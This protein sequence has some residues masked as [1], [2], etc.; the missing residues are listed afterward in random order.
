[1][2]TGVAKNID[3]IA[4]DVHFLA[5]P[6]RLIWHL[7]IIFVL[8]FVSPLIFGAVVLGLI[9]NENFGFAIRNWLLSLGWFPPIWASQFGNPLTKEDVWVLRIA[10]GV[11]GP[12]AFTF[13]FAIVT[14]WREVRR[15]KSRDGV[16]WANIRGLLGMVMSFAGMIASLLF[17]YRYN[18]EGQASL[19]VMALGIMSP[20]LVWYM[21]G[22][23][24]ELA[25]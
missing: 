17:C 19:L 25:G 11:F 21:L 5:A 16:L 2:D 1:M 13:W 4:G 23:L 10:L 14:R 6:F 12:F 9:I 18:V 8:L 20:A 15:T 7:I 3:Q 24:R 22:L